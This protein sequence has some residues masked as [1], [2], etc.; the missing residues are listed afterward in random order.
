M[1]TTASGSLEQAY[2]EAKDSALKFCSPYLVYRPI[3]DN[4]DF[5]TIMS[6]GFFDNITQSPFLTEAVQTIIRTTVVIVTPPA[7]F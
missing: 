4:P 7:S 3:E 6:K 2:A 5:F 1:L